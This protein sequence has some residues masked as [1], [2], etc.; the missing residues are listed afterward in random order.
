LLK[1]G[2]DHRIQ[3]T[4]GV[5]H[6]ALPRQCVCRFGD[7]SDSHSFGG[8]RKCDSPKAQDTARNDRGRTS[9]SPLLATPTAAAADLPELVAPT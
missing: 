3:P 8:P 1:P 5:L 9:G 6:R 4:F 2:L 7:P